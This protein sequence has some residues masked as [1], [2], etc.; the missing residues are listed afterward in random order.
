MTKRIILCADDFGQNEAISEGILRLLQSQRLSATSCMTNM[1]IWP[2]MARKLAA[3][4]GQVQVG[5]HFNLTEG[6]ALSKRGQKLFTSI[7][8]LI[9]RAFLEKLSQSDVEEEL[10]AQLEAFIQA[11]GSKPDFIDGHQHIHHLPI[12]RDALFN[13]YKRYYPHQEAWVRVSSNP[14]FSTL[15]VMSRC[16][17]MLIIT[18]TGALALKKMLVANKI[19]HNTT[20]SG[21]YDFSPTADYALLFSQF[22]KEVDEGGL[23]MCHPGLK[24]DVD[25][26]I[27]A[28][29]TKEWGYFNS[30]LFMETLAQQ[31]VQLFS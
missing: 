2:A 25:D 16:P 14:L 20:F 4:K 22:L 29:R 27:Y 6:Q 18:L 7:N 26:P 31:Q 5:L 9:P 23:I 21:S 13:V 12:I 28:T 15:K 10:S 17:K 24:S 19:P 30:E 11:F 8:Q 3:L 1:P